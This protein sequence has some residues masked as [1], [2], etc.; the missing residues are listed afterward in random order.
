MGIPNDLYMLIDK[1]KELLSTEELYSNSLKLSEKIKPENG[2]D[3]AI[4]LI[5]K[6]S[7]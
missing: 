6:N 1:A 4:E 2:V 3:N 7:C 5:E